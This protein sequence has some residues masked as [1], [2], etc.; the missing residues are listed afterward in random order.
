MST[1]HDNEKKVETNA[2]EA[3]EKLPE[4]QETEPTATKPEERMPQEIDYK[5]LFL[6]ANADLQNFKRRTERERTEWA[7]LMQT[8]V[9][10]K[11]VPVVDD[12]ERAIQTAEQKAPADS[13]S[14]IAGFSLILKSLKKTLQ[15]LGVEEIQ[16][17]GR[18]FDPELHEAL[19]QVDNP[20]HASGHIVEQFSKGFTFKGK[21]IKHAQVSVAK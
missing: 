5:E 9:I 6:R 18:V 17:A 14:W 7:T 15:D 11:I 21:V 10:I 8:N 3:S 19:V 16:T 20:T 13:L 4:T 1:N 2:H 12:L